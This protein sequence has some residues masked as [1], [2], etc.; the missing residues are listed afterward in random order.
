MLDSPRPSPFLCSWWI[1]AT[2]NPG[3]SL[4]AVRDGDTLLGGLALQ[5]RRKGGVPWYTAAGSTLQPDHVDVVSRPNQRDHVGAAITAWLRR[6][7]S[8]VLDLAGIDADAEARN[9]VGPE[10]AVVD[11][12]E[13]A[14][15]CDMSDG[16]DAY[17][18]GASGSARSMVGR[19]APRL[20]REGVSFRLVDGAGIGQALVGFRDLHQNRWG[21][22]SSILPEWSQFA[23]AITAGWRLGSVMLGELVTEMG[24][25][26]AVECVLR[27]GS[28]ACAYQS[29]RLDE[30]QWR[31][32]GSVLQAEMMRA[33]AAAGCTE[34]DL[35]RG[36]EAYKAAWATGQRD[37]LRMRIGVGLRARA[38]L[39]ASMRTRQLRQT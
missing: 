26:I 20:K 13:V 36:G 9:L 1:E 24:V 37:V 11:V 33:A 10:E 8:R 27:A 32:S 29:G 2:A 4:V 18:A 39:T 6:R 12:I 38:V 22:E 31:G 5:R 25:V 19:A 30:R 23:A 34:F 16:Y 14:P 15:Y 35:L 3:L 28:R 21:D 17:L 7:G